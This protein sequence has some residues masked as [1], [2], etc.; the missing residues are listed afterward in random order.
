MKKLILHT[1]VILVYLLNFNSCKDS[2]LHE[3]YE[4][5]E[6]KANLPTTETTFPYRISGPIVRDGIK[7]KS[8]SFLEI[9]N[10]DG[11]CIKLTNCSD[12]VI[13]YCKLGP[14]KNEG[15][16]LY[17][18]KNITVS[19]CSMEDISTG[20]SAVESRGIKV[21]YNDV[22]NVKGPYPRGQMVQ[23]DA[24]YGNGNSI[25]FNVCENIL[26]QSNPED[27]ISLFK[28]NGTEA[29]P[30]QVIGNWIRGGGPSRS[31]GGIIAGD[32]GG[33]FI[34]IEN[35]ILVDPGQYGIAI[36]SGHHI[37]I[38]DNKI[39]AKKQ[40]FT[41]WGLM[42]YIQYPI[43]THSNTMMNNEVN[44]KNKD[45]L[46]RNM[47]NDGKSGDING[48]HSNTYNPNL[49]DSILPEII[50][51]NAHNAAIVLKKISEMKD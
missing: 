41:F 25:S 30:I 13:Q 8:I 43:A 18:C 34:T 26:G 37:T 20:V 5:F 35:N 21:I 22:K 36:T 4:I 50:I 7:N 46:L 12:I 42:A 17:N 31:G 45:G 49:S 24:V 10:P 11:Y 33:S 44:F 15:I 3:S 16:Y 14:S 38:K 6:P 29:D 9:S 47:W 40:P 19:Y 23:F 2:E 51:G 48:W 32:Y 39:Y 27:A 28:S 1:I